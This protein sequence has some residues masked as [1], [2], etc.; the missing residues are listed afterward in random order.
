MTIEIWFV[1]LAFPPALAML[2]VKSTQSV[3]LPRI[4]WKTISYGSL[5]SVFHFSNFHYPRN[6]PF[7]ISILYL[8]YFWV[9]LSISECISL[10]K[11]ALFR[12]L[13]MNNLVSYLCLIDSH[14]FWS[15]PTNKIFFCRKGR[16]Q[17]YLCLW[18]FLMITSWFTTEW[19]EGKTIFINGFPI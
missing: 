19:Y 12:W 9:F 2:L 18:N 1:T 16:E 5:T 14:T 17:Y 3:N 7:I 10:S 6:F 11:L 8:L 13:L 4:V 15:H